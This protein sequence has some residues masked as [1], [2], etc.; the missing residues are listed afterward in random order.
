MY[1][2]DYYKERNVFFISTK[3]MGKKLFLFV[4]YYDTYCSNML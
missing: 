2:K 3:Y 4:M 1:V